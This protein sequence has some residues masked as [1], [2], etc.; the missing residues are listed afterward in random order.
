MIQVDD[1][2]RGVLEVNNLLEHAINLQRNIDFDGVISTLHNYI[3][4]PQWS[5]IVTSAYEA[6]DLI[7]PCTSWNTTVGLLI[8]SYDFSKVGDL[9]NVQFKSRNISLH[10][11]ASLDSNNVRIDFIKDNFLIYF[12]PRIRE[13]DRWFVV[14][15]LVAVLPML[16]HAYRFRR[17]DGSL[18][19]GMGDWN[20]GGEASFCSKERGR[21]LL[22]DPIFVETAG[23]HELRKKFTSVPSHSNRQSRAMWRGSTT[24]TRVTTWRTLPRAIL[25]E[26]GAQNAAIFDCGITH[27]VQCISPEET[28]EV[29]NSDLIKSTIPS[30]NFCDYRFH[31]DID[32]NSNSWP[33]LFIKLLSGGT[34]LKVASPEDYRQWYYDKLIPW[35]H[36]IPVASDMSDL[37]EKVEWAT[38][39]IERAERIGKAGKALADSMTLTNEMDYSICIIERAL[40]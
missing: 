13:H 40:C 2:S 39:N 25:C 8:Q 20:G 4:S 11:D 28:N 6:E 31:I 29:T 30:G 36:Y 35:L 18:Q 24:G 19:I 1:I 22:P 9:L 14:C 37:I 12:H 32:G 21:I 16:H 10:F 38:Q 34:V 17:G 7:I 5:E 15:R 26:I 3:A 27:V 33:G 23:Y